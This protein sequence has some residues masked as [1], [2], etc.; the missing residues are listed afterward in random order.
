MFSSSALKFHM[1]QVPPHF[2]KPFLRDP[3]PSFAI[4][5]F[6]WRHHGCQALRF[7]LCL[8]TLCSPLPT[9]LCLLMLLRLGKFVRSFLLSCNGSSTNS[10][11]SRPSPLFA[12]FSLLL[13]CK[14]RP[15]TTDHMKV[16]QLVDYN[17]I[18]SSR[19]VDD[20]SRQQFQA[21]LT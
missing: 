21:Q 14:L 10:N 3:V 5:C 15:H 7:R 20:K 6:D 11:G 12:V 19:A 8:S 16:H 18:I 1:K 13:F 9:K 2:V 4:Y 17:M